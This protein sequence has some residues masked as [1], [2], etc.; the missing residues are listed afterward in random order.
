MQEEREILLKETFLEFKKL[1]KERFVEVTEIDLRTGISPEQADNG[2]IIKVCL[3]EV[4]RCSDSPIFF[5]GMLGNR[6]GSTNWLDDV[7]SNTLKDN[8]YKWINDFS[9]RSITELE[10]I[11]AIERYKKHNRAFFYLK[12]GKDDNPKLTNLKN[13]LQSKAHNN[14]SV[15]NYKDNDNFKKQVIDSLTKALDELYPKDEKISEVE[16]LRASHEI[17]AKSRQKVY[18]PHRKNE[19][20]LDEFIESSQDRLLLYGESGLGKSALI[21]NYFDK[22]KNRSDFFVIEHY[23]GGAGELS[24]DLHQMLRR[25][26]LEIKE[27]F[28]LTDKV[29]SEPQKIMDEFA[30][31]LHRVKRSTVIVLDGYNQIEDELKEKLFYYIPEKLEH[32][33]L[34]ISS[35][36]KSYPIENSHQIEPL[37]QEEQRI[38]VVDYLRGYGKTIERPILSNIIEHPQTTNTLFLRTLL[39]EIRLLG[40]FDNLQSDIE[41]YLNAKDVVELFI[42]IFERLESDYRENLAKEVLSLLYVSRDGLSEDNLMEIINQNTTKK[43]TRLKFSP[44]FLAIEEH[45]INR[46][47]LYGFFHDFIRLAVK[48]R[49]LSG[50]ELVDG[51]RRKIADY[52]EGREIDNQ[53]VR[54]LPFQLFELGDRDGLY[55]NLLSVEFFT[56]IADRNEFELS[57]YVYELD[58]EF[59][60]IF[61]DKLSNNHYSDELIVKLA[62]FFHVINPK[63]D[64]SLFLYKKVL[65][66]RKR[67]PNHPKIGATYN[68]LA[69]LYKSMGKYTESLKY[70]EKSLEV[71]EK[72]FGEYNPIFLDSY[73]NLGE[74]YEKIG[75]YDK[76]LSI[77]NKVLEKNFNMDTSSVSILYDCIGRI[78]QTKNQYKEA[79]K[80]YKKALIIHE[81]IFGTNHANIATGY[82]NIGIIYNDMGKYNQ[83]LNYLDK[84]LQMRKNIFPSNH[85][86]FAS[87]YTNIANTYEYIGN[88][89]KALDFYEKA[90]KIFKMHL[91]NK[92]DKVATVSDLIGGLYHKINQYEKAL[93]FYEKA[94]EI[95]E[96][97]LGTQH[98]STI[99]SYNNLGGLYNSLEKYEK[100]EEFYTKALMLNIQ[101]LGEKHLN[102]A[103]FYNNLAELYRII[104]NY[105]KSESMH[106]KA[107]DIKIDILDKGHPDVAI[108]YNNLGVLYQSLEEYVKAE[109]CHKKALDIRINRFGKHHHL[110]SQSYYNLGVLFYLWGFYD[111]S[112]P[113]YKE[114]LKISKKILKEENLYMANIY[115][116]L[117]VIYY[118]LE[119]YK[120]AYEHM[121]KAVKIRKNLLPMFHSKTMDSEDSLIIIEVALEEKR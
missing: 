112:E 66:N 69:N 7:D 30:L 38:L 88:F 51:E 76:A 39:N 75:N 1:A 87:L 103:T 47:G 42:K 119:N 97:A 80:F 28:E 3:D 36:K 60:N 109:I 16:K 22:F 5:L 77:Y 55:Q 31:W 24:N 63:Y 15:T 94:L 40:N 4:E 45:L 113:Y 100:A 23:I 32:V 46:G 34:I 61:V 93:S 25:I 11:S 111:E 17:F 101:I 116:E 27:E 52:F 58:D 114:A 13:R 33:K 105:K 59:I 108:S 62:S 41:N 71:R 68:S 115:N 9:D 19:S 48:N 81:R 110:T 118:K 92:H 18:I 84:S 98:K 21:A 82:N 99:E 95:R 29:P 90:L 44:L 20:I 56:K 83:A 102:T 117:G 74:L 104:G 57:K 78:Y 64:K 37:T 120:N 2:E 121:N 26:M 49:Y 6:Y 54:E 12:E 10:I 65:K 86:A 50:K 85:L 91:G 96:K 70:F 72:Q 107:L 43:L 35:I 53:R 8:R 14:L 89:E 67:V 79:L 73:R 106:N